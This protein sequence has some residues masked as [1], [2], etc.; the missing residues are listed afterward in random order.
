M[1]PLRVSTGIGM[2]EATSNRSASPMK[3]TSGIERDVYSIFHIQA[4]DR[5]TV[6]RQLSD[7][8]CANVCVRTV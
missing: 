6:E 2:E 5:A 4:L 3:Y 7:S 8:V 1:P